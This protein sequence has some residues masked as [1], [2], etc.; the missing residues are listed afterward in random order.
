MRPKSSLRHLY[1][2][3]RERTPQHYDK[4]TRD[5]YI[6]CMPQKRLYKRLPIRARVDL[7]SHSE[8]LSLRT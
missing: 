6:P 3:V 4:H 2:L 8:F 5:S 1:E 7:R